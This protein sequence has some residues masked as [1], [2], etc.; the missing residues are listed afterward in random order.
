ME[1]SESVGME[2]SR[3]S[4]PLS[5]QVGATEEVKSKAPSA[6]PQQ[7]DSD[8]S[9]DPSSGSEMSAQ[10]EGSGEAISLDCILTPMTEVPHDYMI[11]I[12]SSITPSLLEKGPNSMCVSFCY[13]GVQVSSQVTRHGCK[14]SSSAPPPRS[15]DAFGPQA[16]EKLRFPPTDGVAQ[17]E[18]LQA[19]QELLTFLERGVMLDSN[20]NGIF[21]SR[22]CQ[23]RVFWSGPCAPR[24]NRPNKLERDRVEKLFDRQKFDQ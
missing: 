5:S 15:D 24:P 12:T 9:S 7:M 2:T 22:L 16:L 21:A 3:P 1:G 4:S 14:I 6:E 13:G 23:G 8:S 17:P 11:N 10:E 19:T 20:A 18:K